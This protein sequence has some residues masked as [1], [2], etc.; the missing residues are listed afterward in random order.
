MWDF[1]LCVFVCLFLYQALQ[2]WISLCFTDKAR[3]WCCDWKIWWIKVVSFSGVSPPVRPFHS[4]CSFAYTSLLFYAYISFQVTALP[5]FEES[6]LDNRPLG[7]FFQLSAKLGN[8][9]NYS[10]W[11]KVVFLVGGTYLFF[12]K[13]R[14]NEQMSHGLEM[15][16]GTCGRTPILWKVRCRGLNGKR[17]PCGFL[18]KP[19][20]WG[21]DVDRGGRKWM[22]AA[23]EFTVHLCSSVARNSGGCQG[24]ERQPQTARISPS[25]LL[26][27]S[28]SQVTRR[29]RKRAL[30]SAQLMSPC[31]GIFPLP[32]WRQ[33]N[34]Q[35]SGWSSHI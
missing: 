24:G 23:S 18:L 2:K 28:G 29:K 27:R 13:K 32:L 33:T 11:K 22:S 4:F 3:G 34:S 12:F 5:Q 31:G 6:K 20:P 16:F 14:I 35:Q 30:L 19:Q 8:R 15:T 9:K 17:G 26:F 1:F 25:S 7:N 21:A 10:Y